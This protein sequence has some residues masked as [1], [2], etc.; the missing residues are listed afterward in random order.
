MCVPQY[1]VFVR[2]LI[3]E[4]SKSIREQL[5]EKEEIDRTCYSSNYDSNLG[6]I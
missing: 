6:C 3:T 4:G 5:K 1:H 2:Q